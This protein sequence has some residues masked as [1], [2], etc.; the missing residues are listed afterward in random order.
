MTEEGNL[1]AVTELSIS[2]PSQSLT[3][4]FGCSDGY[5]II[6]HLESHG[7]LQT[8][9][10][11]LPLDMKHPMPGDVSL[12]NMQ[13]PQTFSVQ[14]DSRSLHYYVP[15]LA[16]T[17]AAKA[18]GI[19]PREGLNCSQWIVPD[20]NLYHLALS[21]SPHLQH[22]AESKWIIDH[23]LSAMLGHVLLQYAGHD[24]RSIPVRGNLTPWQHKIVM[25]MLR[26]RLAQG[27]S[28]DELAAACRLSVSSFAR[29]FKVS[30]GCSPHEWLIQQR[31]EHATSIMRSTQLS[32]A[33]IAQAVGFSDQSHFTRMFGKCMGTSPGAWRAGRETMRQ[34][35]PRS[36]VGGPQASEL[37]EA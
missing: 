23:L 27:V 17:E 9:R 35:L 25:D 2:A 5:L 13:V 33:E 34:F 12:V 3:S 6:V 22:S 30:T 16:L 29:A 31:V 19:N 24:V 36:T 18:L 4:P 37:V 1:L 7:G 20:P 32:L 28:V 15:R 10:N 26:E 8:W 14:A 21:L 11:G